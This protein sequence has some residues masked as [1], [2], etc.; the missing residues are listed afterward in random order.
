LARPDEGRFV[1][2][3]TQVRIKVAD[4]PLKPQHQG[5]EQIRQRARRHLVDIDTRD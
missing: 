3:L 2:R 5:P 1:C 4:F